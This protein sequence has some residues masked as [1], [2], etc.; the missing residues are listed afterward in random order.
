MMIFD[1]QNSDNNTLKK[2]TT[3]KHFIMFLCAIVV[4]PMA[5]A[6][7]TNN[8][9]SNNPA[10]Q[11]QLKEGVMKKD[12]KIWYIRK[13]TGDMNLDNGV[14]A[15]TDGTI[16][17]YSG[18]TFTLNNGDCV[19]FKGEMVGLNQKLS[20]VDGLVMKKN[21]EMWVWS[22]LSRPL[23]LKNGTYATADGTI[24]QTNGSFTK[25]KDNEFVDMDGNSTM[26]GKK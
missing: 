23:L 13:M 21:G 8:Q 4:M 3:M 7:Q 24:R 5:F 14:K 25:I 15:S 26:M 11:T 19:N 2:N 6:Q 18:K 9:S 16:K 17:L 10:P 20:T 12:G 1:V 22:V